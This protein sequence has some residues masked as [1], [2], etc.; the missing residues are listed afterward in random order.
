VRQ[1]EAE[2]DELA[3]VVTQ[4]LQHVLLEVNVSSE[5]MLVH[6]LVAGEPQRIEDKTTARKEIVADREKQ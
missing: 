2:G 4:S 3:A 6:R 5:V 1:V